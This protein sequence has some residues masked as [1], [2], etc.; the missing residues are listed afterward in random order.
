MLAELAGAV[1]DGQVSPTELVEESLRRIEA[2][3]SHDQRRHRAAGRRGAGRGGGASPRRRAGRTAAARQGHG[4]LRRACARRWARRCS[5]T[6]RPTRSTTSSSPG[7]GPPAPSWS[8]GPTRRRSATPAFTTNT[9]FGS[10]RNPWNPERSPGGSSG[11]LGGRAGRRAGA[12]GHDVRRRRLGAHPGRAA[13]GWSATSRRWARSA[14]T[15]S[16]AGSASR[17]RARRVARWPTSCWRP[18]S[19]TARPSATSSACPW[20]PP[21]S[22]PA[23]RPGSS[24]AARFRAD[25]DPVIEAAFEEALAAAGRR[26]VRR[27]SGS[28]PPSDPSVAAAWFTI[29]SAELAQ[30]L[31]E[32]RDQWETFEPSL[33][34]QLLFGEAVTGQQYIEATRRRFEVAARFDTLLGAGRRARHPRVERPELAARGPAARMR[35]RRHGRPHDRPQHART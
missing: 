11:G 19:P 30:S 14:A 33:S 28:S 34:F 9:L 35:R 32:H 6:R 7:S 18:P 17:P 31:A 4:P 3:P 24:P 16:R 13:A 8:V 29:S 5:P 27:S 15:S 26:R 20:A 21:A 23:G 1:R 22:S 10:T 2:S 25:V 12:A